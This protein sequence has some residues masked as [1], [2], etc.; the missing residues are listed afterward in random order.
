MDDFDEGFLA[1]GYHFILCEQLEGLR[2]QR[3]RGYDLAIGMI[4]NVQRAIAQHASAGRLT[5]AGLSMTTAAL[6]HAGIPASAELQTAI[7]SS[8]AAEASTDP[9]SET[10]VAGLLEM[11]AEMCDGDP[12]LLI[13]QLAEAGHGMPVEARANMVVAMSAAGDATA[14]EAAILMLLDP[15]PAIRDAVLAALER[16]AHAIS[17]VTLRRRSRC[18]TGFRPTCVAGSTASCERRAPEVS[19]ARPGPRVPRTRFQASGLDGSGAQTAL[20]VS[21]VGRR[22]RLTSMLFKR[23]LRDVWIG[24]PQSAREL[25]SVLSKA[26]REVVLMPVSQG[27]LDR[28]VCHGMQLALDAGVCPPV[29]L[30]QAAELVGAA[31]GS[32][33]AR[34]GV[35]FS[36]R[37]SPTFRRH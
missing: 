9:P 10:E 19:N 26:G 21:S 23:G 12:F 14:R 1:Q 13:E 7:E 6:H 15:A 36:P 31:H 28:I 32:R 35:S 5:G 17:S 30:L 4:E 24:A 27:Y 34:I 33:N 25:A 29:G 2:F 16:G 22:K 8:I 20:I 18:E 37:W 11:I 3:D